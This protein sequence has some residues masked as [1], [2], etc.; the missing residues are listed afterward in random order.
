MSIK[1]APEL[2]AL[3]DALEALPG[4]GP[5]TA[6][7]LAFH[8]LNHSETVLTPLSDALNGV[9]SGLGRCAMCNSFSQTS[10]C[11]VCSDPRREGRLL[12]VVESV[13]DQLAV[14]AS[15]AWP[16]RYF[17]LN[18]RLN[19]IEGRGPFEIGL[20]QLLQ[21]VKT[22]EGPAGLDEVVIATSYTP[23]GDAT[24]YYAIDMIKKAFP[25]LKVTRL[26][27]GV[28][29]GVEIEYTDLNTLANALYQRR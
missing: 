18:G 29:A 15:L 7:R 28:P 1:L 11:A 20:D 12:C 14:D 19:P 5:R 26:A 4:I 21:V 3:I 13:A 25:D 6:Q 27:R 8:L 24:A 10:P 23:E 22:L 2:V 17:V 16:G 9:R